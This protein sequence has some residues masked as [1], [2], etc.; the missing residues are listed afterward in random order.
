MKKG[1]NTKD[2]DKCGKMSAMKCPLKNVN[3]WYKMIA[4]HFQAVSVFTQQLCN[5]SGS[6][7]TETLLIVWFIIILFTWLIRY[8]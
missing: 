6:H 2:K 8:I 1:I 7:Q 5:K 4:I 3:S